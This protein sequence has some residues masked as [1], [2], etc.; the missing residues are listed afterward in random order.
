MWQAFE[1]ILN[2]VTFAEAGEPE[3]ALSLLSG[4][5]QK[6]ESV[7]NATEEG[8]GISERAQQY[9]Q[10]ITFAE[11]G[12]HQYAKEALEEAEPA[13]RPADTKSILVLGNEDTFPDYLIDYAVDMAERFDYEIIAL[14][15]LPMS[16]KTRVLSG[17]ADEIGER[18]RTNA[19]NAGEVF[20]KRAEERGVRFR[21]E[22][23]LM[24][25]QKAIRHLHKKEDN[26]EFV[27]TEPENASSEQAPECQGSV[28]VC[29]LV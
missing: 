4:D 7:E 17:F 6:S 10:A 1:R 15:A 13:A 12:E 29:S 28:C 26:I 24:S 25:E 18:F 2:A 8:V 27:L 20:R 3:T 9:M 21:Q 5:A 14:N 22:I 23:E 19:G 16:R 11:E